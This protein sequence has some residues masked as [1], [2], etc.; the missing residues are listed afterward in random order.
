[1]ASKQM[2]LVHIKALDKTGIKEDALKKCSDPSSGT[3]STRIAC[4]VH[5]MVFQT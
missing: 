5:L 1:M 3:G 2:N 4:S